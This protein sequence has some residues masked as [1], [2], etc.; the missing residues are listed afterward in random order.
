MVGHSRDRQRFQSTAPRRGLVPR[1]LVNA[2]RIA[3]CG[4]PFILE[5]VPGDNEVNR[6]IAYGKASPVEDTSEPRVRNQKV[7]GLQVRVNPD[8][9]RLPSA[10]CRATSAA[11]GQ[12]PTARRRSAGS[13][14][15]QACP[16]SRTRHVPG[17]GSGTV[18]DGISVTEAPW[19]ATRTVLG[20]SAGPG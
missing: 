15:E 18:A 8:L 7:P 14:S 2:C 3:K 9:L 16:A 17:S 10:A 1:R 4:A 12:S 5:Q 19:P 13:G 6:R 20:R 11:G